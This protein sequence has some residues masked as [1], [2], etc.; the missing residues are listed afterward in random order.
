MTGQSMV[1]MAQETAKEDHHDSNFEG[2][3]RGE[4]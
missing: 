4:S 3:I 2:S 1:G